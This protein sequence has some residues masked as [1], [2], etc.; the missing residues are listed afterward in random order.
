MAR[1]SL[2]NVNASEVESLQYWTAVQTPND[3]TEVV[4]DKSWM[5]TARAISPRNCLHNIAL[6]GVTECSRKTRI[7]VQGIREKSQ[8]TT[9]TEARSLSGHNPVKA[10]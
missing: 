5:R 3:R 9:A 6:L 4:L 10:A 1:G 8:P 2:V 7:T